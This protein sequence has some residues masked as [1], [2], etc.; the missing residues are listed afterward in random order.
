ETGIADFPAVTRAF[1]AGVADA[2]GEVRTG[3][4]VL[5]IRRET[6]GLVVETAAGAVHARHLVNCAGLQADRVARLAGVDPGVRI[7]PFRGEYYKLKP[8]RRHLVK[9]LIYPVPDPQFPFLGVHF[10]RMIDGEVEAGP[11]AVLSLKREGYN[12]TS[13]SLKEFAEIAAYPGMRRLAARYWKEGAR[14]V[15]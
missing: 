11:N 6:A 3:S 13:F 2:G 4:R 12:R 8:E 7:V 14:E 10:T 5:G 1:A 15:V 9:H